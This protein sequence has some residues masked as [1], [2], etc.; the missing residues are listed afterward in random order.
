MRQL[1]SAEEMPGSYGLPLACFW[2]VR[3]RAKLSKLVSGLHNC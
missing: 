1:K 2:E 3:T